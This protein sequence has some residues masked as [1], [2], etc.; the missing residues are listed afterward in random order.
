MSLME[1]VLNEVSLDPRI[2]DGVFSI[3]ENSHMDV[4]REYFIGRGIDESS[5]IEYCNLVLEG[6]YPERQAYNQ[7][8]ILV[9]FPTAE[10]KQRAIERGTH[11]EKD[12][13]KGQSN[14]FGQP[15][16]PATPAGQQAPQPPAEAPQQG[17]T[18]PATPV[19]NLPLSQTPP[20]TTP[21]EGQNGKPEQTPQPPA[22]AAAP[23]QVPTAPSEPVVQPEEPAP[24]PPPKSP[25]EKDADEKTIKQM[26]RGDDYM[27]E[28]VVKYI[29]AVNPN[30]I[31]NLRKKSV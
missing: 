16:K 27:L 20:P 30:I 10:Y 21:P 9:T 23:V 11:F 31:E 22:T 2:R 28:Q 7:K 17:A 15:G 29:V 26:L 18:A 3:E 19:T 25:A 14:L 12:P 4:L 13:T 6:K 8:G 24:E 1:K 5:A